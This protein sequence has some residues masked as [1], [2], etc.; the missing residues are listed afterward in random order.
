MNES[1]KSSCCVVSLSATT[2]WGR[3]SLIRSDEALWRNVIFSIKNLKNHNKVKVFVRFE[4]SRPPN[5]PLRMVW[6]CRYTYPTNKFGSR[7]WGALVLHGSSPTRSFTPFELAAHSRLSPFLSLFSVLPLSFSRE[8]VN[9][10]AL[11]ALLFAFQLLKAFLRF[12]NDNL[13]KQGVLGEVSPDPGFFLHFATTPGEDCAKTH[14]ES[15]LLQD[16]YKAFANG[17]TRLL[18]FLFLFFPAIWC[19]SLVTVY[20]IPAV[21]SYSYSPLSLFLLWYAFL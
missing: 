20:L 21:S 6:W 3:P 13:M 5:H 10:T 4:P 12:L 14:T 9:N 7:L 17:T 11:R 2:R 15:A 16:L 19:T 1:R 18:C 8:N